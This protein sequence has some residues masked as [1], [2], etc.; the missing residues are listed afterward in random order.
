MIFSIISMVFT[1]IFKLVP[2]LA[3][4]YTSYKRDIAVQETERQGMWS[5]A[6]VHAAQT[7]VENRKIAAAERANSPMLMFLY[8]LILIGPILYY[9]LFWFDTIFA[10]QVWELD[11]YFFTIPIWDWQAYELTRAPDRLE[12]MGVWLIGIFV[13]G[14]TAV[15]GVV[16]G[17]RAL[18][19]GGLLKGR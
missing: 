18:Q 8:F 6:L 9:M 4:T 12:E 11:L 17:A 3:G 2:G 15:N 19:L 13:G 10:N 1:G 14:N 5:Q 7:D 16:K